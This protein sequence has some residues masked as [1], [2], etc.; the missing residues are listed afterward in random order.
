MGLA[1]CVSPGATTSQMR[2]GEYN[3]SARNSRCQFPSKQE[4]G[5]ILSCDVC[6]VSLDMCV[7]A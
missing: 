6:D 5:G 1:L 3:N 4:E 2:R 7:F